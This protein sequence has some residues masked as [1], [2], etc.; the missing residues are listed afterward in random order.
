MLPAEAKRLRCRS[1]T[2]LGR[3]VVPLVCRT[4]ATSS[5]PGAPAVLDGSRGAALS[6][7]S[8]P[9]ASIWASTRL[10]PDG[11]ARRGFALAG[12]D[13]EYCRAGVLQV[14]AKLFLFICSV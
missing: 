4:R 12:R 1:G 7:A 2:S 14:E 3:L 13:D 5:S 8:F 9:W 6:I 10:T 11:I